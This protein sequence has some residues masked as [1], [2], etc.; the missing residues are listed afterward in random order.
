MLTVA[1]CSIRQILPSVTGAQVT[2]LWGSGLIKTA[3]L[4]ITIHD[5]LSA[6]ALFFGCLLALL[7]FCREKNFSNHG[8]LDQE[9]GR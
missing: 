1:K 9:A 8:R 3:F 7:G 6:T 4:S 2:G 5:P